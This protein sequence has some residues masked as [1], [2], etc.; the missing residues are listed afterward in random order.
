MGFLIS[1]GNWLFTAALVVLVGIG[2]L[3]L[4]AL[5]VGGSV[6]SAMDGV[7]GEMPEAG[8]LAWLHVGRLPFLVVLVLLLAS[9]SLF[10][11]ALQGLTAIFFGQG[12]PALVASPLAFLA[13]LPATRVAGS[14]LVRI[15]PR[16]ESAAISASSFVGRTATLTSGAAS[17]GRAAEARFQD[18]FGQTHYVM[19]EPDAT[20]PT[21]NAGERVLLLRELSSGRYQA[22]ANQITE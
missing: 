21:L 20:S 13:A 11:F 10:G 12:M 5:L 6:S 8:G 3:E 7:I 16:D 1:E 22:T 18:E 19:V 17:P 2:V 15:L 4:I 9:F 14:T